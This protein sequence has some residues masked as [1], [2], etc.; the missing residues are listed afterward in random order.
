M[1]PIGPGQSGILD[2]FA[3]LLVGT[4]WGRSSTF[5]C[6]HLQYIVD[7]GDVGLLILLCQSR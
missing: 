2:E 4:L 7:I 3:F 1:G 6:D 5:V